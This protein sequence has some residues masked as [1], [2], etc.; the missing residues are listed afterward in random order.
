MVLEILLDSN[1]RIVPSNTINVQPMT[2][3]FNPLKPATK[4]QPAREQKTLNDRVPDVAVEVEIATE[5]DVSGTILTAEEGKQCSGNRRVVTRYLVKFSCCVLIAFPVSLHY[6]HMSM[7]HN[8]TPLN[9]CL[10]SNVRLRTYHPLP[11]TLK[12]NVYD[13]TIPSCRI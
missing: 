7:K 3:H 12:T 5:G 4:A 10:G 1:C 13:D 2:V 9:I 11:R 6:F 8:R